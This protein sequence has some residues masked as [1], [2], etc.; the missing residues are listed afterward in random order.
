M[1]GDTLKALP[2]SPPLPLEPP[3]NGCAAGAV[4]RFVENLLL[5]GRTL[6]ITGT[7]CHVSKSNIFALINGPGMEVTGSFRFW[8]SDRGRLR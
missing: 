2:L 1:Q 3:A 5:E 8:R 7:T 4:K 6:A